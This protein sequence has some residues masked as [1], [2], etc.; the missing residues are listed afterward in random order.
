MEF[1]LRYVQE[2][3]PT[4][5]GNYLHMRDDEDR[6]VRYGSQVSALKSS[7]IY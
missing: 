2:W 4:E 3:G 5:V 7:S 6:G 1:D